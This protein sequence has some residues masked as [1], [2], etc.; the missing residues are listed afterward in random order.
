M[1]RKRG[2]RL[3]PPPSP[4]GDPTAPGPPGAPAPDD[5]HPLDTSDP[6]GAPPP[7]RDPDAGIKRVKKPTLEQVEQWCRRDRELWRKR[8]ER[9]QRH[10]K[11]WRLDKPPRD[12][13]K[14][15]LL[16]TTNDP[17]VFIEKAASMAVA[18]EHRIEVPPKGEQHLETAGRI[19]NACRWYRSFQRRRWREAGHNFLDWDQAVCLF[20]RGWLVTRMML[21]PDSRT[22]VDEQLFDPMCVYPRWG[23]KRAIRVCHVYKTTV[24]ALRDDFGDLPEVFDLKED[25]DTVE[26]KSVYLNAPPYWHCVV[27]DGQWVKEPTGL[28]YWPWV[29]TT[30]KGAFSHHASDFEAAEDAAEHVGQGFLD[31]IEDAYRDLCDLLTIQMNL[32]A[33]QENP[34]LLTESPGGQ[35][36]EV[37][38]GIGGRTPLPPGS[39]V[40]PLEV[41]AKLQTIEAAL[42]AFQD[43]ENKGAFPGV[44]WGE[45]TGLNSG[46]Q[47]ALLLEAVTHSLTPFMRAKESHH[48]ARYEKWLELVRDYGLD[49][50]VEIVAK[51]GATSG[52]KPTPRALRGRRAWGTVL[53][54]KDIEDNGTDVE[55]V[56]EDISPQDKMAL[57]NQAVQLVASGILDLRTAREQYVGVDDPD[58]VNERALAD[59]VNKNPAAVELLS[60]LALRRTGRWNE[61]QALRAADA[62]RALMAAGP[63]GAP[64]GAPPGMAPHPPRETINWK[65]IPPEAQAAMLQQAGL[66]APGAGGPPPNGGPGGPPPPAGP[67]APPGA[68]AGPPGAAPPPLPPGVTPEMLQHAEQVF[69]TLPPAVQ[70]VVG[71]LPVQQVVHLLGLP[72]REMMRAMSGMA[73]GSAPSRPPGPPAPPSTPGHVLPP[74]HGQGPASAQ[75]QI[76]QRMARVGLVPARR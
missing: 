51:T 48:A 66:P 19:E 25:E 55:V 15:M 42:S 37:D 14:G 2:R 40:A 7:E 45:G 69:R 63:P 6:A 12:R 30:A 44:A 58:V 71:R 23:A 36:L 73:S 10:H 4:A 34:P 16:V 57:A 33:K 54:P 64:P 59:L 27:V 62:Q 5:Q 41:G 76:A 18:R 11:L 39:K 24:G 28:D 26:V 74:Q 43:R 65:D 53:T 31:T 8:D 21:D 13:T 3:P 17:K 60:E 46:Y 68:P 56:Y 75:Q 47:S 22:Y 20:L 70:A 67:P 50:G 1:A 9:Q 72:P 61:L 52:G 49:K 29:V 35:P 38:T 32:I